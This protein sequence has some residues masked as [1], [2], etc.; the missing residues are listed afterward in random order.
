MIPPFNSTESKTKSSTTDPASPSKPLEGSAENTAQSPSTGSPT[1]TLPS[2]ATESKTESSTTG[3]PTPTTPPS[4]G[5][6]ILS[7]PPK[8]PDALML[9]SD[10]RLFTKVE[11][12]L[13]TG[14]R[15]VPGIKLIPEKEA[16]FTWHGSRIP[17]RLWEQIVCF[18]RWSQETHHQEALLTLFYNTNE[19]LWAAD[20]FPQRPAGMTVNY[21]PDHPDYKIVRKRYGTG[22][23]QM[24]SVH[25]HCGMAAFQ[26]GTDHSDEIDRDGFHVTLGKMREKELDIHCRASFEGVMYNTS[27]ELWIE[28]PKWMLEIP[29]SYIGSIVSLSKAY[30]IPKDVS[31]PEDWKQR[32]VLCGNGVHHN[33]GQSSFPGYGYGHDGQETEWEAHQRAQQDAKKTDD[34]AGGEDSTGTRAEDNGAT[35]TPPKTTD[36]SPTKFTFT[37]FD[38]LTLKKGFSIFTELGLD[39]VTGYELMNM[40]PDSIKEQEQRELRTAI[41]CE[42]KEKQVQPM[43]FMTLLERIGAADL[44]SNQVPKKK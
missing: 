13:Y 16:R 36:L 31:F 9:V 38:R 4:N 20:V 14:W 32:I 2:G 39:G 1:Q 11:T 22:W 29:K 5:K 42:L 27:P 12:P 8:P 21:L 44:V 34:G 3:Q 7:P 43:L 15:K 30:V 28:C 37:D 41:F 33:G 24:G 23:V 17:F 18:M 40:S 10:N 26:S 19:K 35:K 25:H 6:T